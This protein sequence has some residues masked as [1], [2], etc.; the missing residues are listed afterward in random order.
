MQLDVS[1]GRASSPRSAVLGCAR[2][3]HPLS[4]QGVLRNSG[5]EAWKARS[6]RAHE[7]DARARAGSLVFGVCDHA[8]HGLTNGALSLNGDAVFRDGFEPL[9]PGCIRIPFNDL[10]AL[11]RALSSREIAAFIVEPIQGKAS[12]C[13]PTANLQAPPSFAAGHGTLVFV[14]DE[15]RPAWAAPAASLRSST[16]TSNRTWCAVEVAVRARPRTEQRRADAPAYLREDVRPHGS[17]RGA[18]LDLAKNDLAMAAGIA[19][20]DVIEQERL[21]E[22]RG[23][24]GRSSDARTPAL[25]PHIRNAASRARQRTDDRHRIRTARLVSIEGLWSVLETANKGL[26][27]QLITIPLFKEQKILCQVAGH[28]AT[29][30]SCCQHSSSPTRIATGSSALSTR[31]IAEATASGR[32]VV[33]GQN[34]HQ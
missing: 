24:H 15:S 2:T 19:T 4:R 11:E 34:P 14:A 23:A 3:S 1:T 26:F 5:A 22:K 6:S 29:P 17:G 25:I 30:S 8:Y 13:R 7:E 21:I 32:G 20:L 33:V 28:A 18:W 16:G 27:C 12:T 10:G 31:V 9:L